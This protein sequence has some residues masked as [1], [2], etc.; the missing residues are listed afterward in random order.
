MRSTATAVITRIVGEVQKMP[1]EM[2]PA[3][4]PHWSQPKSFA[5]LASHLAHLP[6]SAADAAAVTAFHD[7]PIAVI[8]PRD[9]RPEVQRQHERLGTMSRR[10][11]HVVA[12][13]GGHWI[14]SIDD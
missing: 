13:T 3:I 11:R 14:Q 7:I 9:L 10:G 6:A 5:S 12:T 1:A 2:R 4:Q 8:F